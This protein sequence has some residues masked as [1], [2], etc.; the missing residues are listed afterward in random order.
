MGS[1]VGRLVAKVQVS[2]VGRSPSVLKFCSIYAPPAGFEPAH[3]APEGNA[4]YS[5]YQAKHVTSSPV[6]GRMGRSTSQANLLG[7]AAAGRARVLVALPQLKSPITISSMTGQA[8]VSSSPVRTFLRIFSRAWDGLR[9]AP[10]AD[11][12][13]PGS[14]SGAA[15]IAETKDALICCCGAG[16]G[17]AIRRCAKRLGRLRAHRRPVPHWPAVTGGRQGRR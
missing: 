10:G 1:E 4:V 16:R 5:R 15:G 13:K 9:Q 2:E 12:E 6:G 17:C 11:R 7:K 8:A 3:T 14:R